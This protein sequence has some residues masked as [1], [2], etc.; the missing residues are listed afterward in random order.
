VVF[1]ALVEVE[2]DRLK[3]VMRLQPLEEL[4][5]VVVLLERPEVDYLV[6]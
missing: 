6:H 2:E 1:V 5:F 4:S 3:L